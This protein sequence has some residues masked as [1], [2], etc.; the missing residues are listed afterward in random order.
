MSFVSQYRAGAASATSVAAMCAALVGH[1]RLLLRLVQRDLSSRYRGSWVGMFW[2]VLLPCVMLA[3]Y[4]FVFGYIFVPARGVG[5]PGRGTD[6]A[7]SLFAGLLLHGLLAECLSRGPAAVLSQPSYVKKVVFPIELLPMTVVGTATVQFLIGSGILLVA[8]SLSQ[9]LPEIALLWPLA[10]LP[11]V[12]LA[13]GVAFALAALTVYL[14]D[15][16]Q[17]TGFVS[18]VL[19]FLSPVFYPLSS[20]PERWRTLLLLNPLTIPIE[21]TRALLIDGRWPG[22]FLWGWHAMACL[23]IL[24]AGWWVFQR[25][26]RG[27]ADVI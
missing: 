23:V 19:M 3:I 26:R 1:R 14:R 15:L 20:V 7:L 25:S 16:A 2:S 6:F 4:V 13:A 22:S 27:F 9:G 10:W 12:A 5:T 8:L 21:T 24:Y 17:I 18:T 11:L